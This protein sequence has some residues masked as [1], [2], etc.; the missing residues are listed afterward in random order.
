M[1]AEEA[2]KRGF[3]EITA[4]GLSGQSSSGGTIADLEK[5]VASQWSFTPR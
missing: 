4:A 3:I 1:T 5:L 2:G